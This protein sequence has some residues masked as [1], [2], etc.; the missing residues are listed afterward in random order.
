MSVAVALW[1]TVVFPFVHE[2]VKLI[3]PVTGTVWA[4]MGLA[5]EPQ[6]VMVSLPLIFVGPLCIAEAGETEQLMPLPRPEETHQVS[7]EASP[8]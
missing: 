7:V 6:L 2:R 1:D 3:E 5:E 8:L 4:V